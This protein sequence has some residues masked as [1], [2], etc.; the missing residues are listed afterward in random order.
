MPVAIKW[1]SK[2]AKQGN[3]HAQNELAGCY[4]NGTGVIKDQA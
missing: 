4:L 2:S 3:A 1:L